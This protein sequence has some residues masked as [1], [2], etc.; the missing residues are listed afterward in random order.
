MKKLF[1]IGLA[2]YFL[3][4]HAQQ[5]KGELQTVFKYAIDSIVAK[6]IPPNDT[7]L[8]RS[9]TTNISLITT[10]NS[11]LDNFLSTSAKDDVQKFKEAINSSKEVNLKDIFDGTRKVSFIDSIPENLLVL[12]KIR[13]TNVICMFSNPAFNLAADRCIFS[14]EIIKSGG[15]VILFKKEM[16]KWS[17]DKTICEWYE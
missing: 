4:C 16:G 13:R 6:D 10:C 17:V 12:N 3:S 11:N 2:Q 7:I 15:A 9:F 1:L 5:P 14:Y 8:V